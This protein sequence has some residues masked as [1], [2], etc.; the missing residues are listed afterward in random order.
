VGNNVAELILKLKD[1]ASDKLQGLSTRLNAL[2][3]NWLAVTA[4]ATAMTAVVVSSVKEYLESERAVNRLNVALKN[5]GIFSQ[6]MSKHLQ[7]YA[8]DLSRAT[9]FTDEAILETQTMLT[10]F[11]LAGEQMKAV[12]RAALDLSKGL[13]IDLRTAT[14]LMG[15]A[16]AGETATLARYGIKIDETASSGGKLAAVLQQINARFGG[17]AQ[18]ELNTYAGR[19][20]NLS[21]RFQD[22]KE[23]LGK[24]VIPL[25]ELMLGY[26][27]RVVTGL[28]KVSTAFD[29]LGFA[30]GIL[31]SLIEITRHWVNAWLSLLER[32]PMLSK[33]IGL[34]KTAFNAA[35][36]AMEE[37]IGAVDKADEK[38][39]QDILDRSRKTTEA[40]RKEAKS[41]ADNEAAAR[42]SME[43]AR[44]RGYDES[45]VGQL[46]EME[47]AHKKSFEQQAN[48]HQLMR[49]RMI[50]E[51]KRWEQLSVDAIFKIRDG[52]ASA[53]ADMI[54]EGENFRMSME[55]LGKNILKFFIEEVIKQMIAR[56]IAGMAIM[57]AASA[58]V[59]VPGA[60]AAGAVGGAAGAAAGFS[61]LAGLAG[62][63]GLGAIHA[64]LNAQEGKPPVTLEDLAMFPL[65]V[66]KDVLK[67][68][69][70]DKAI[71]K[72]FGKSPQDIGETSIEGQRGIYERQNRGETVDLRGTGFQ[73]NVIYRTFRDQFGREPS[74]HEL[75]RLR[76]YAAG[77]G[78]FER[79]IQSVR[80][81]M[82]G[83]LQLA[84][85]GVIMPRMGGT[86][87]RIGEGGRAEAVIP[88]DDPRTQKKLGRLIGGPTIV[89]NAGTLV[90]DRMSVREL[91]KKIDEELYRLQ[92]RGTS[93]SD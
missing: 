8:K 72:I 86:L 42:K 73:A 10:T 92:R 88:L 7:D 64:N 31:T 39:N 33:E 74:Q 67:L 40:L 30:K 1:L 78:G 70:L 48:F 58:A 55:Q 93:V 79:G 34:A 62:I 4:A 87:A 24:A 11:G 71:G 19:I 44:K 9:T 13:E 35:M 18:S 3:G 83:R 84:Q 21:N 80:E 41:R 82:A 46:A 68:T 59:A 65:T 25:L 76:E 12:T 2:R 45:A 6:E 14:L 43:A 29:R 77:E 47:R 81:Y 51:D 50:R 32:I 17:S 5:Q 63:A 53:F 91:A 36:D 27:D 85:G 15:K 90:A 54:V 60:G 23:T 52:F 26:L 28:E 69:K 49:A 89:I 61:A 66:T 22:L 38:L 57:N 20:T 16:A 37:K 75:D 56:W